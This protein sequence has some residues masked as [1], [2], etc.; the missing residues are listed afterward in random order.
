MS[1]QHKQALYLG[2][3]PRAPRLPT[4]IDALLSSAVL[5]FTPAPRTAAAQRA[6]HISALIADALQ[7]AA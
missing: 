2:I 5:A 4:D 6:D 1:T 3:V 7:T